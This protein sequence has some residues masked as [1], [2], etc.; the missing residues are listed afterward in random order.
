MAGIGTEILSGNN[1]GFSGALAVNQGFLQ[2]GNGNAIG[3]PSQLTI[4]STAT[5][6]FSNGVSTH[7]FLLGGATSTPLVINDGATLDFGVGAGTTDELV[8]QSGSASINGTITINLSLLSPAGVNTLTPIIFSAGGGLGLSSGTFVLAPMSPLLT[9]SIQQT[10]TSVSVILFTTTPT[11]YWTGTGSTSPGQW[12]DFTNFTSDAAG[13]NVI[14]G[15]FGAVQDVVFSGSGAQNQGFSV[16][17]YNAVIHSLTINDPTQVNIVSFSNTLTISGITT[18]SNTT[19]INIGSLA[20]AGVIEAPVI[21]AGTPNITVNN[22]SGF[23]VSGNISGT[24]GLIVNG[25]GLLVLAGANT[26]TGGTLL[27]SGTLNISSDTALGASG[28][29]NGLTFSGT[30]NATLQSGVPG[31]STA[32]N[33][34]IAFSSG[35]GT[36]DPGA[37]NTMTLAGNVSGSGAMNVVD[38][39]RVIL[40]GSVGYTGTSTISSGTLTLTLPGTVA[41]TGTSIYNIA[42]GST[43]ELNAAVAQNLAPTAQGSVTFT[44]NGTLLKTGTAALEFHN[45][46]NT[47]TGIVMSMTGGTIE[48]AGGLF[49]NGGSGGTG[50]IGNPSQGNG[51]LTWTN[52]KASLKIDAGA[53]V[54]PWDGNTIIV[55]ALL[56]SGTLTRLGFS[57]GQN[58][59]VTIGVNNGSGEFDGVITNAFGTNSILKEGTGLEIFTGHNS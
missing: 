47:A 41:Q 10:A 15:A 53:S 24:N 38:N 51:S 3:S 33:R 12:S 2:L 13:N 28:S 55:D 59:V 4:G 43:L 20:A 52:N 46:A 18:G 54:D 37:G 58:S 35:T 30:G 29:G 34:T 56:G 22:S 23:T 44:G 17:D 8:L 19:G 49:E 7:T 14:A 16:V 9:G 57:N 36:L 32:N 1:S 42:L 31:L 45:T 50:S 26:Y 21:M 6:N 40:S 48:I 39:G 25:T 11:V 27:Q 5:V